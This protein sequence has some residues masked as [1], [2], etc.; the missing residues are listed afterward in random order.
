MQE[1]KD[2]PPA[3]EP[4]EISIKEIA[5]LA[6]DRHYYI[7]DAPSEMKTVHGFLDGFEAGFAA[8]FTVFGEDFKREKDLTTQAFKRTQLLND[9]T[10]QFEWRFRLIGLISLGAR[11][12]Q[13][14][15][16]EIKEKI[17]REIV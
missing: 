6:H 4:Q 16:K 13:S 2:A 7:E 10:A 11:I 17:R 5:K 12:Y 8:A 3:A 15:P 9:R 1:N 14:L